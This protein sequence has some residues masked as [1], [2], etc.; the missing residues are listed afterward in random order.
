MTTATICT[1]GDEILIGQIVDTNS[2]HIARALIEIGVKVDGMISIGDDR[3]RI[4]SSLSDALDHSDVVIVTGGLGPTKDDITKDALREISGSKGYRRSEEQL[5]HVER[6][7][8]ARGIPM[9]ETNLAQADVPEDCI[10][11]VNELGTAPGMA[12]HNLG[13][14][15]K[16][17]LYSL[18]GVPF[19]AVGI[20]PQVVADIVKAHKTNPISHN[21]V[22]TFGIAESVLANKIMTWEESLPDDVKLAYL[23]NPTLGVRLRLTHFGGYRDMS[24]YVSELKS[25][26]GDAVYGEGEDSLQTVIGRWLRDHGKTLAL[27]ESCTGGHLSELITSVAGCSD[28]YKGSV[29]SYANSV[30][31]GVLGVDPVV[32]ERFGAVSREC[33]EQ[34]ATG[35]LRLMDTDY[36]VATSG[37]AG[38]G[39]GSDQKPVGTAWLGVA[40]KV[41]G[42]IKVETECVHFASS[43]AVN[44]ERFASNALNLLRKNL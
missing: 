11:L 15:H 26:L 29:T 4:I 35:V 36:G 33:V 40:K 7:L 3:E 37:I 27:A 23:P 9:L 21:T 8:K 28:Y 18:P 6:I 32:I 1:I 42:E 44:I 30:K 24:K 25:I 13:K 38:P 17:S 19:E 2:S 20:L 12:F 43:R 31:I 39:G 16:S 14:C 5:R 34:M 41:G 10:V 22:V